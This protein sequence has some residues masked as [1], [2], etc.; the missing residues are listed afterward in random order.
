MRF[1]KGLTTHDV[2]LKSK[3]DGMELITKPK[4]AVEPPIKPSQ[5]VG[6][7]SDGNR[8]KAKDQKNHS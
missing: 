2:T 4:R 6:W 5:R 3:A 7:F 1:M 8:L